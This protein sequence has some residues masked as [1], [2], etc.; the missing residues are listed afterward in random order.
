MRESNALREFAGIQT[1]CKYL[2]CLAGVLLLAILFS[3]AV[4][5]QTSAKKKIAVTFNSSDARL[6]QV[7]DEYAKLAQDVIARNKSV[8][9]VVVQGQTEQAAE[10]ARKI[11]ADFLISVEVSPRPTASVEWG[12]GTP[13][14]FPTPER[15]EA[16]GS[17]IAKYKVLR[18]DGKFEASDSW[19]VRPETYPLGP[20]WDWLRT[21]APREVQA[22][23]AGAMG[24]LKKK[25]QL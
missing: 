23:T 8:E 1:R 13:N 24:K 15:A 12:K 4:M 25:K 22:A 6:Q 9:A 21:I 14:P 17:I 5:A 18:L 16:E 20:R 10:N 19:T 7:R 3:S 2:V 11:G